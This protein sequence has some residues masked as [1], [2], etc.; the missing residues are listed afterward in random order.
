MARPQGVTA[1][2]NYPGLRRTADCPLE[3]IVR[4]SEVLQ[5]S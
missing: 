4:E 5:G 3:H 1:P 2:V